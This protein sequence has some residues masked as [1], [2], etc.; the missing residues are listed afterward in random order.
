MRSSNRPGVK[1]ES[2]SRNRAGRHSS[3]R[4]QELR[5]SRC[6]LGA[7]EKAGAPDSDNRADDRGAN[8]VR[9]EVEAEVNAGDADSE[10]KEQRSDRRP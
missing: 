8:H 1:G 9:R 4:Q 10:R 2:V 5:E 3:W 6:Y 7:R